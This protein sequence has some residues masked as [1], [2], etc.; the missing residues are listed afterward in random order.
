M[1][2][3]TFKK[4]ESCGNIHRSPPLDLTCLRWKESDEFNALVEAMGRTEAKRRRYI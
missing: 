3:E 4:L 1:T 2:Q